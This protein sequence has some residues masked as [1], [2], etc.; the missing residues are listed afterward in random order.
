MTHLL[1]LALAGLCAGLLLIIAAE[2]FVVNQD[3]FQT[4]E[5]PP[6][7]P[8]ASKTFRPAFDM[9]SAIAIILERPLFSPTRD[10]PDPPPDTTEPPQS[11][12][13]Q[14][15]ARLAGVMIRPG[16][17]EALFARVGQKP[18]PV[19]IGGEIDGWTIAA[20]ELDRVVLANAFGSQIV[21]PTSGVRLIPTSLAATSA[22]GAMVSILGAMSP[23][24][25]PQ[26]E[27]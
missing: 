4:A 14:L 8:D 25:R 23:Q 27:K 22:R 13:P 1:Q 24:A 21:R 17:R 7:T 11:A 5:V 16:V 9:E 10:L 26:A 12:P 18:I 15:G 6:R 2:L 19:K 3:E 20:I